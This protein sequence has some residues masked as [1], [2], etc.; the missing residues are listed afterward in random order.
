M[1]VALK[2]CDCGGERTRPDFSYCNACHCK[3][4]RRYRK[5]RKATAEQTRK[6]SVRSYAN[7]YKKRGKL[8]Q[9]PCCKC[10]AANSQMHHHDYGRPTDVEWL[11]GTCHLAWHKLC[12]AMMKTVFAQWVA[13][14]GTQD[15]KREAIRK[16]EAA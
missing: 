10:G 12:L 15:V 3:R 2:C 11:C 1:T 16:A 4:M 14:T 7:S 5:A 13:P 6:D 9:R 8:I